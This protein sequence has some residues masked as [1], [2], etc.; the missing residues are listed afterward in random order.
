MRNKNGFSLV[1]TVVLLTVMVLVGALG[2]MAYNNFVANTDGK[3]TSTSD[4]S[5]SPNPSVSPVVVKST[6][7]LDKISKELDSMSLEDS[8]SSSQYDTAANSF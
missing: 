5:T 1:E 8:D 3:A 7:D 6:S 4:M 2:Y